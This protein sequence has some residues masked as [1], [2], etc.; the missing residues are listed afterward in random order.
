[1][2]R[3]KINVHGYI[4]KGRFVRSHTRQ[5]LF[6]D[7]KM[8]TVHILDPMRPKDLGDK[9]I[10][11]EGW[12]AEEKKD[13]SLTVQYSVPG[14]VAYLNRRGVNKTPVYPELT[15]NEIKKLKIK[16]MTI[17]EGE[18]YALKGRKDNFENFLRRD[19]LQNPEEA[20]KRMKKYPLRFEAFD[21]PMKDNKWITDKPLSE[22]K[23][24]LDRTIPKTKEFLVTK[25]SKRP[26]EFTE[27]LSKDKTV[28]GVVYKKF[29]SIYKSGKQP[30][31]LKKKFTREAD[32]VLT[33]YERG[34]GKRKDIGIVKAG[35]W[36]KKTHKVVEIANVGTGFTDSQLKDIK[37]RLDRGERLFAKVGYLHPG[38]QGRLRVPVFIGLRDD[39]NSVKQTHI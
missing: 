23:E 26:K 2:K 14:A 7:G 11:E 28:E 5:V 32:V 3:K 35:V 20:K 29:N 12:I 6:S 9:P 10:P 27:R 17:T 13:G 34:E 33:G 18:A 25:F 31:W 4:R 39:L 24:I 37:Q 21:M 36:D 38:G 1:M 16:G 19:L 30:D 8:R 15:D 22:R